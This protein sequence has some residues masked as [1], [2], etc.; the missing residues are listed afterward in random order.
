MIRLIKDEGVDRLRLILSPSSVIC[1]R[2]V[3][4]IG[5]YW[6]FNFINAYAIIL[7]EQRGHVTMDGGRL[8]D[9]AIKSDICLVIF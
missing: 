8:C 5:L 6:C 1:P 2:G 9:N 4:V 7:S 3:R